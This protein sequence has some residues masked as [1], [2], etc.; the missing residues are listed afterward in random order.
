MFSATT[1]SVSTEDT[2]NEY[3]RDDR[4]EQ[5][6]QGQQKEL[7]SVR[8]PQRVAQI[9]I[10]QTEI[11]EEEIK[12][13]KRCCEKGEAEQPKH[14][15]D[16]QASCRRTHRRSNEPLDAAFIASRPGLPA[17]PHLILAYQNRDLLLL[18][19]SKGDAPDRVRLVAHWRS[20]DGEQGI[21]VLLCLLSPDLDSPSEFGNG[22]CALSRAKET[23]GGV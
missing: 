15:P 18:G 16:H 22:R 14:S 11:A 21:H 6:R 1:A 4:D 20:L 13:K 19:S 2:S 8:L 3:Q 12:A 17:P 23:L 9:Y 7:V 10:D 5:R